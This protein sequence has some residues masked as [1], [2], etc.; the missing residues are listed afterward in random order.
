M[1]VLVFAIKCN[2]GLS[3]RRSNIKHSK[4]FNILYITVNVWLAFFNFLFL[5]SKKKKQNLETFKVDKE[6]HTDIKF[7]AVDLKKYFNVIYV[8]NV[9]ST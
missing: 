8:T 5:I 7:K 4:C 9:I 6:S 3:I 1:C 2:I